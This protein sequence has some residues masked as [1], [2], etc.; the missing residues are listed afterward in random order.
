MNIKNL[1][2]SRVGAVILTTVTIALMSN[3]CGDVN[4]SEYDDSFNQ[5]LDIY[6][7]VSID[8]LENIPDT[9]YKVKVSDPVYDDGSFHFYEHWEPIDSIDHIYAMARE[10]NIDYQVLKINLEDGVYKIYKKTVDD[11]DDRPRG[12]DYVFKDDYI[13]EKDYEDVYLVKGKVLK[14]EG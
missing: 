13:I 14:R 1:K 11:I 12:Y 6:G 5:V 2:V 3:G 4:A 8:D 7:I 9:Y 10:Y